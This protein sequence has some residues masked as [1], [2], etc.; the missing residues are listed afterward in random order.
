MASL[1]LLTLGI[2][3]VALTFGITFFSHSFL[4]VKINPID[5]IDP[6]ELVTAL[7]NDSFGVGWSALVEKVVSERSKS[8][9]ELNS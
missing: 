5:S 4:S 9:N 3:S 6:C 8:A 2:S 7:K 1:N